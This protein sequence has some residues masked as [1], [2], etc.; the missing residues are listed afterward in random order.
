MIKHFYSIPQY[1]ALALMALVT[2][3]IICAILGFEYDIR[4]VEFLYTTLVIIFV[5]GAI[6]L[7]A[8]AHYRSFKLCKNN[9]I[10]SVA[11]F[12]LSIVA[13]I[14]FECT[15]SKTAFLI[16]I[17]TV[18]LMFAS[19]CLLVRTGKAAI[20]GMYIAVTIIMLFPLILSY[21]IA[22]ITFDDPLV[23]LPVTSPDGK[24]AARVTLLD[25]GAL[26]YDGERVEI[27]YNFEIDLGVVTLKPKPLKS[28]HSYN[29]EYN[30]EFPSIEWVDKNTVLVGGARYDI[31]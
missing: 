1:V 31:K 22:V 11:V 9:Y 14:V 19:A 8:H 2:P 20:G 12:P 10:A 25:S 7:R 30:G 27:L 24:Y 21:F 3:Y 28:Y 17:S 13:W 5:F 29:E 15:F 4:G 16:P 18:I 23:S 26:G 6:W